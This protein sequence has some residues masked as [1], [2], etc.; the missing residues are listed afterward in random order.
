MD[1]SYLAYCSYLVFCMFVRH[2]RRRREREG[3][4]ASEAGPYGNWF[5]L[6]FCQSVETQPGRAR[7]HLT[8]SATERPLSL[9]SAS[10]LPSSPS[11]GALPSHQS[12]SVSPP[13]PSPPTPPPARSSPTIRPFVRPSPQ[14]CSTVPGSAGGSV[15]ASRKLPPRSFFFKHTCIFWGGGAIWLWMFEVVFR[16][17]SRPEK[18]RRTLFFKLFF[19]RFVHQKRH[20]GL[21]L[22][23][24]TSQ[25]SARTGIGNSHRVADR[26]SGQKMWS[27]GVTALYFCLVCVFVCSG[28]NPPPLPSL[29]QP[30]FRAWLATSDGQL[31]QAV[32]Y[33]IILYS[34][35]TVYKF[36]YMY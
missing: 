5:R 32:L 15:A 23:A 22:R 6:T 20:T 11:Y 33:P 14:I 7:T 1:P 25:L 19:F 13:L 9:L 2:G 36:I 12:G 35:A 24:I 34:T 26:E 16:L 8:G 29:P 21:L 17:P 4:A 3:V 10:L 28:S 30:V 18:E 27:G 31:R